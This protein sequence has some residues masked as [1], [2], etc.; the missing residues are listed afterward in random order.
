METI[1]VVAIG[2]INPGKITVLKEISNKCIEITKN[3]DTGTIQYLWFFNEEKNECRIIEEYENS[4]AILVHTA[5]LSEILPEA[6]EISTFRY[7]MYGNV[8]DEFKKAVAAFDISFFD[9]EAGM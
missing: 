8:S 7:E 6:M 2:K 4:D 3:K 5:N 9:Y 1:K